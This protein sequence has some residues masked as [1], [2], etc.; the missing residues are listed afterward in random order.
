MGQLS[1]ANG[2]KFENLIQVV[3]HYSRTPDGLLRSLGDVCSVNMFSPMESEVRHGPLRID[4]SEI[5][6]RGELGNG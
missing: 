3:D 4:E 1:I 2:R 5:F 6:I